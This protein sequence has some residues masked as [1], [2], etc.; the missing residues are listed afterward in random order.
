MSE[1]DRGKPW[2]AAL[3]RVPSGLFVLTARHGSEEA[4]MLASFVQQCSFDPPLVSVALRRG[5][6]FQSWLRP[7][8]TVVVNLLD[9]G[10]T[11]MVAFFGRGVDPGV[12]VFAEL[13]LERTADGTAVLAE[14]L[15]FLACRVESSIP[16]GDHELLLLRVVDGRLLGEGKPMVHIRKNGLHY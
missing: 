5:S 6:T 11:D 2:A 16:T 15:A 4:G 8:D 12:N 14:A 13:E 10:Q 9:D 7:G 3:G 1:A